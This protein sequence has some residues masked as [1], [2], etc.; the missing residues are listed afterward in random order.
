MRVKYL[1]ITMAA[2]TTGISRALAHTRD[3][4]KRSVKKSTVGELSHEK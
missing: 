4:W 3:E 2:L 1:L